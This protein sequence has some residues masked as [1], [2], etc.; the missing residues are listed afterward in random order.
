MKNIYCPKLY[1]EQMVNHTYTWHNINDNSGKN[2]DITTSAKGSEVKMYVPQ[3][4]VDSK[5]I[6]NQVNRNKV[7]G[8]G[9][10]TI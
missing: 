9:R 4:H 1:R 2:G 6:H 8:A 3:V 5:F 10:N 7:L